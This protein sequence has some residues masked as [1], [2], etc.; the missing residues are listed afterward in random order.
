MSANMKWVTRIGAG[1]G[2]AALAVG[3]LAGVGNAVGSA[4][5]EGG[6]DRDSP[7]RNN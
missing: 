1:A 4:D 2:V 6:K 3:A 5:K 7:Q